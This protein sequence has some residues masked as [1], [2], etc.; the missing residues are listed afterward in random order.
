MDLLLQT[1]VVEEQTYAVPLIAPDN[2]PEGEKA[3]PKKKFRRIRV[4]RP[5]KAQQVLI[6]T[7]GEKLESI[8]EEVEEEDDGDQCMEDATSE[9]QTGSELSPS[10][11][12][13]AG[14]FH[15][16]SCLEEAVTDRHSPLADGVDGLLSLSLQ[17]PD[18][19]QRELAGTAPASDADAASEGDL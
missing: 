13:A 10:S 8:G 1:G 4:R 7:S 18:V 2:E 12:E 19:A 5:K 15:E 16:M 6:T 17:I 14:S 3:K 9:S 11:S